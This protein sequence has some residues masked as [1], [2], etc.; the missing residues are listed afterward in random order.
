MAVDLKVW[1]RMV[2]GVVVEGDLFFNANIFQADNQD[3]AHWCGDASGMISKPLMLDL[4][5]S[6]FYAWPIDEGEDVP[7]PLPS[8]CPTP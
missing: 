6:T 8:E 5:G 1:C 4:Q 2:E 7:D 3:R